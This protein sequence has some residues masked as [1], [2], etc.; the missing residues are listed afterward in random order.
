[1]PG[2]PE[3]ITLKQIVHKTRSWTKYI[4]SKWIIICIVGITGGIL[5]LLYATFSKPTY[6][7]SVSFILSNSS[8]SSSSIAG[9]VSQFGID[10]SNTSNDAFTGEN[11]IS[12][13][14]SRAMV[15]KALLQKPANETLLNI[16]CRESKLNEGW[17][18]EART[19]NAFPFPH[20]NSQMTPVQDSLFRDVY[21][22]VIEH[23]LTVSKPEEDQSIYTVT[24]KSTN[25]TFS[26]YLTKYL[27]NVTSVFY[28]DTKTSLAKKNLAMLQHEAD[29]LRHLLGGAIISTASETDQTFNL[30]P[31]YQVKRAASQQS[32]A[33]ASVLGVAYGEIVKDIEIA[34]ITL[35]KE[36]PLYQIIDEPVLP[37]EMQKESRLKW[38]LIGGFLGGFIMIVFFTVKKAIS[39]LLQ[40]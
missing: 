17:Q 6:S 23:L 25:E 20:E 28:I 8:S 34:K 35:L 24:T 15:Q 9:L 14:S 33:R 39:Y 4:L 10:L 40:D 22:S 27:V 32:Q 2:M 29:S 38:L 36:T 5:G 18:K 21:K 1:M 31:A 13:M 16:L 30:N 12:L 37:L 3:E 7:A 19:K 26:F 11:I